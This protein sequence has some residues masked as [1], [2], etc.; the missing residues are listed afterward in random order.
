MHGRS[1]YAAIRSLLPCLCSSTSRKIQLFQSLMGHCHQFPSSSIAAAN[2]EVKQVLDYPEN[3]KKNQSI[4]INRSIVK[5][6]SANFSIH[7]IRESI[8]PRTFPAIRYSLLGSDFS[9]ENVQ[10]YTSHVLLREYEDEDYYYYYYYSLD[11]F[12]TGITTWRQLIAIM[13]TMKHCKYADSIRNF[14]EP[15]TGNFGEIPYSITHIPLLT[16]D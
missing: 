15:V 6:F 7:A 16:L 4:V 3:G 12:L 9:V 2:K 11:E 8:L 14:A 10:K 13:D 5:D 1:V